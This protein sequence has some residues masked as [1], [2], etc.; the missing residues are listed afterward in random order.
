MGTEPDPQ[1]TTRQWHEQQRACKGW[2]EGDRNG[3]DVDGQLWRQDD[4]GGGRRD[5]KS[6]GRRRG[7][8]VK[9]QTHA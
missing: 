4:D 7:R 5:R 2:N 3:W 1:R 8:R 9:S 6:E